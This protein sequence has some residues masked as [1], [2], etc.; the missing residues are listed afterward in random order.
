[1]ETVLS[2]FEKWK[3]FLSERVSQAEKT[4]MSDELINKLAYQI[5]DF[6]ANHVDPENVQERLLKDLWDV[7]SDEEQR[8]LAKLMVKLVDKQ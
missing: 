4:G 2:V 7:A 6:L 1:M 3:Q 5:G 8:V